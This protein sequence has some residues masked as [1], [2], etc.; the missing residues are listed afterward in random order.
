[1]N[2]VAFDRPILQ[3]VDELKNYAPE[4]AED[5]QKTVAERKNS[6]PYY[7]VIVGEDV[8]SHVPVKDFEFPPD[9][10]VVRFQPGD[11]YKETRHGP[12]S[13]C[14]ID[15][16]T[17]DLTEH[18][19]VLLPNGL[20]MK[21]F[22]QNAKIGNDA[23][24]DA[25]NEALTFFEVME[26][27]DAVVLSESQRLTEA[28]LETTDLF[29]S[30]L[31]GLPFPNRIRGRLPLIY[32]HKMAEEIDPSE[33]LKISAAN[34]D[35]L[36]GLKNLVASFEY[37]SDNLED[38]PGYKAFLE[39]L[40]EIFGSVRHEQYNTLRR[41]FVQQVKQRYAEAE[42]NLELLRSQRKIRMKYD[43]TKQQEAELHW[44]SKWAGH[45]KQAQRDLTDILIS[46]K[47]ELLENFKT[48]TNGAATIYSQVTDLVS[49]IENDADADVVLY[50][51]NRIMTEG[52]TTAIVSMLS[53][54]NAALEV[55][56]TD[57]ITELAEDLDKLGLP[58]IPARVAQVIFSTPKPAMEI[59]EIT[60]ELP[61]WVESN[62]RHVLFGSVGY[63]IIG[64]KLLAV[65][66]TAGIKAGI[67]AGILNSAWAT[68]AIIPI[69]AAIG[70]AIG[71]L[72]SLYMS[73]KQTQR[74]IKAIKSEF[75]AKTKEVLRELGAQAERVYNAFS[76][77][78]Q[79]QIED[80]QLELFKA[81]DI[82]I[83]ET[84]ADFESVSN[85]TP[86][87]F[88]AYITQ[89]EA[90]VESL[91]RL[92]KRLEDLNVKIDAG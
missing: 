44:M 68:P 84:M 35:T 83:K 76:I 63:S 86:A 41:E 31:T 88:D 71:L 59:T 90:I 82:H 48:T 21:N 52:C 16:E 85:K 30:V 92:V 46:G 89:H 7:A 64:E 38:D 25:D 2:H 32:L 61:S 14:I 91:N 47:N 79:R 55:L 62:F 29:L 42:E 34:Q 56:C 69:C 27:V 74:Q 10:Q 22:A 72:C 12:E 51:V 66:V 65:G 24:N 60:A 40:T 37:Y 11:T 3:A 19:V 8:Q 43:K 6:F 26:G 58:A 1:M 73:R 80:Y 87:E 9:C 67:E 75:T 15:I 39:K 70:A 54:K 77:S 49:E 33:S 36:S 17:P 28:S 20:S 45:S 50:Q 81:A 23:D 18:A 53:Q 5:F 4:L 78:W 57:Q 13:Q